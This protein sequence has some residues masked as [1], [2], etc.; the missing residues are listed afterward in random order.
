FADLS[1]REPEQAELIWQE[2][3]KSMANLS[4]DSTFEIVESSGHDIHIYQPQ[5]VVEAMIR[6]YTR[7][8]VCDT[9]PFS[10]L[11]HI[12]IHTYCR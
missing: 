9:P 3:Q 6:T 5:V 4:S 12:D 11:R 1:V 8:L 2:L 7:R 10:W